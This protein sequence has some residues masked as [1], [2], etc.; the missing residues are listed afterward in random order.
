MQDQELQPSCPSC[1]AVLQKKP[2]RKTKCPSC[3][4]NIFVRSTQKIFPSFF[5]SEDDARAVD[6]LKK[7]EMFGI[8][9][10]EFLD[11]KK[12]LCDK[13]GGRAKSTDIIWSLLNGLIAKTKKF[14]ELS[15]V[16]SQMAWFVYEEG[17][18]CF[19][20]LQQFPWLRDYWK[21]LL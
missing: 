19:P 13:F 1:N 20:V 12:E 11:K 4:K 3:S 2:V 8:H 15:M 7:L 10:G 17:K 18:D 16:Y 9:E 5:L 21:T 6:W 14:D